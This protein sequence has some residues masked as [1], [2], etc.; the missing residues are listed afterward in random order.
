VICSQAQAQRWPTGLRGTDLPSY[1]VGAGRQGQHC[2]DGI[3]TPELSLALIGDA[4]G[5]KP[6]RKLAPCA[7]PYRAFA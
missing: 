2:A 1:E 6:V 7:D 4:S 5:Q 3:T